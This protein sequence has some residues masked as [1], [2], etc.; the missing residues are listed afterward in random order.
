MHKWIGVEIFTPLCSRFTPHSL[1]QKAHEN[2]VLYI[3]PLIFKTAGEIL[4]FRYQH[5]NSLQNLKQTNIS[6]SAFSITLLTLGKNPGD[7]V[8]WQLILFFC[9]N[10]CPNLHCQ[11]SKTMGLQHN[12]ESLDTQC[13][14]LVH[15]HRRSQDL[16][17]GGSFL[18]RGGRF[19][20]NSRFLR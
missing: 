12:N 3:T 19:V 9:H 17:R 1:K 16:Q 11:M 4:K 5:R 2:K 20:K 6:E 14:N 7:E 18:Q 8:Y 15:C 13:T 10:L